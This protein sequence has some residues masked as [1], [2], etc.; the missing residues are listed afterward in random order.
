M[1]APE[2]GAHTHTHTNIHAHKH[3]H[4]YK[5]QRLESRATCIELGAEVMF[6]CHW[7]MIM[8]MMMEKEQG[9]EPIVYSTSK[10]SEMK[11]ALS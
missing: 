10:N 5:W 2:G 7:M 8:M 1:D 6:G 3:T 4:T 11:A 9:N